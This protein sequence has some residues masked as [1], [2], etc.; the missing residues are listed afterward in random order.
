MRTRQSVWTWHHSRL[1]YIPL[2]LSIAEGY[3]VAHSA[4]LSLL[5]NRLSTHLRASDCLNNYV[6]LGMIEKDDRV[7]VHGFGPGKVLGVYIGN[8]YPIHI[9]FDNGDCRT[10]K[11]EEICSSDYCASLVRDGYNDWRLDPESGECVR[12]VEE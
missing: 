4:A 7:D 3:G 5:P 8:N 11:E 10:F 2:G 1:G 12:G 9:L 6:G